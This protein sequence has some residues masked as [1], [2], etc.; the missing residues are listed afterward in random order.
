MAGGGVMVNQH[1]GKGMRFAPHA[2][3]DD[4]LLD[5]IYLVGSSCL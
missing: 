2:R 3:M 5:L 1:F 4:G